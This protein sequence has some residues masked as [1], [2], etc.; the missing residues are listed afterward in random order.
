LSSNA[1][2]FKILQE[3]FCYRVFGCA[4]PHDRSHR[5]RG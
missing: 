4:Q 2:I 3:M 1:V 5:Q